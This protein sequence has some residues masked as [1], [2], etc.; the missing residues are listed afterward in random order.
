MNYGFPLF[1]LYSQTEFSFSQYPEGTLDANVSNN[2]NGEQNRRIQE[3]AKEQ[4]KRAKW[5]AHRGEKEQMSQ[6]TELANSDKKRNDSFNIDNQ[7]KQFSLNFANSQFEQQFRSTSD[8]AS[9]ISLVA[10]PLTLLCAFVAHLYLYDVQAK[11]TI[12]YAGS[13]TL[14]ALVVLVCVMPYLCNRAASGSTAASSN[15]DQVSRRGI[16]A[17]KPQ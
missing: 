8:I 11:V 4:V 9:C 14:L 5:R 17:P 7:I 2:A 12:I 6:E 13:F 15:L 1:I 16:R 3:P 10:L